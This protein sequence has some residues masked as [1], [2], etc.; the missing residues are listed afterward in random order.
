MEKKIVLFVCTGNSCR[1][2]IAEE[3]FKRM[4]QES[5]ESNPSGKDILSQIEVRSAGVA[6]LAGMNPPPGTLKVMRRE[7]IDVSGHRAISLYPELVRKSSLIVVMERKHQEEVLDMVHE[8][9]DKVFLLKSFSE[10][11]SEHELD[12]SDPIGHSL[13]VYKRCT[14]EIKKGLDGFLA[15]ILSGKLRLE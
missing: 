5:V 14:S 12:L 6:P 7:G 15:Q 2:L 13:D 8:S 10:V 3:L 4:L 11:S 1:S 9:G